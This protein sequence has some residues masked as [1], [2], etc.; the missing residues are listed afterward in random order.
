MKKLLTRLSVGLFA[1]IL[2][3]VLG[4]YTPVALWAEWRCR[5]AGYSHAR[6]TWALERFCIG[7]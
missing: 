5:D 3:Y 1:A 6:V 4:V 7:E 2:I